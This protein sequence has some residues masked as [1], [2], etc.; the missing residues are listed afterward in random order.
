MT[1][2]DIMAVFAFSVDK[3]EVVGV[4]PSTRSVGNVGKVKQLRTDKVSF[5]K[6]ESKDVGHGELLAALLFIMVVH[7]PV[8]S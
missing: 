3:A 1:R 6:A 7:C 8:L 4:F 2:M 5:D